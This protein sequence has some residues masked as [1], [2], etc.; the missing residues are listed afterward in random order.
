MRQ[1]SCVNNVDFEPLKTVQAILTGKCSWHLDVIHSFVGFRLCQLVVTE[2][3]FLQCELCKRGRNKMPSL[4]WQEKTLDYER[5]YARFVLGDD[6]TWLEH[7][8]D[9]WQ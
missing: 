7:C 9:I 3:S 8:N 4:D 1:F 5:N 6:E 2:C